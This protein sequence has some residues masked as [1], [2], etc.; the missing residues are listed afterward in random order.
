M[1]PQNQALGELHDEERQPHHE[2]K[3]EIDDRDGHEIG[4]DH[5]FRFIPELAQTMRPG[6]AG[7]L[8]LLE[9]LLDAASRCQ[10]EKQDPDEDYELPRRG[11]HAGHH[12]GDEVGQTHAVAIGGRIDA[13]RLLNRV[14]D[15]F[16]FEQQRAQL[17]ELRTQ[18]LPDLRQTRRPLLEGEKAKAHRDGGQHEENADHNGGRHGGRQPEP[19]KPVLGGAE[20]KTKEERADDRNQQRLGKARGCDRQD[21][22]DAN[23]GDLGRR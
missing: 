17:E 1:P 6:L 19:F 8:Q 13:R 10:Q 15:V 23:E 18:G 12:F 5:G 11:R 14:L 2:P 20:Q 3:P 9:P 7:I 21:N 4:R 22:E 16:Q